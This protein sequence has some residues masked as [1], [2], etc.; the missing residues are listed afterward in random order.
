MKN[1]PNMNVV[2]IIS[3]IL[4]DNDKEKLILMIVKPVDD[5]SDRSSQPRL[6]HYKNR[7]KLKN[8]YLRSRIICCNDFYSDLFFNSMIKH[9]MICINEKNI[10]FILPDIEEK[11]EM[12]EYFDLDSITYYHDNCFYIPDELF[13]RSNYDDV[14][15]YSSNRD[16]L[17]KPIGIINP[18]LL[19]GTINRKQLII[20][21]LRKVYTNISAIKDKCK[22]GE[23]CRSF[24]GFVQDDF[25]FND[26]HNV[27]LWNDFEDMKLGEGSVNKVNGIFHINTEEFIARGKLKYKKKDKMSSKSSFNLILKTNFDYKIIK[28]SICDLYNRTFHKIE[29]NLEKDDEFISKSWF[30]WQ[31]TSEKKG[32]Q[33]LSY[34]FLS[35]FSYLGK[36]I[37]I[38]DPYLIGFL[39]TDNKTNYLNILNA[40]AAFIN[41]VIIHLFHWNWEAQ[42]TIIG[43]TSRSDLN[44]KDDLP[45]YENY[46]SLYKLPKL[47]YPDMINFIFVSEDFHGRY[48]FKKEADNDGILLLK[49]VVVTNS[50]ANI[51][52]VDFMVVEDNKQKDI[53]TRKYLSMY[54]SFGII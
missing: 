53:I 42:V 13:N 14:C 54:K 8:T 4:E 50:I 31:Y 9:R 16:S 2:L 10:E 46:L 49:P 51:K 26:D 1:K 18:N 29:D 36:D 27:E 48:Y 15:G 11:N 37:V 3:Q 20:R 44:V 47:L 33:Q 28:N 43:S 19:F 30:I 17:I 40:R 25:S 52:E 32:Y 21:V 45:K 41:A 34:D 23:G 24:I 5:Y 7:Y 38:F 35:V 22:E 39:D 6:I 12:S